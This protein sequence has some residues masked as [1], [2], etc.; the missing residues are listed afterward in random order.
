MTHESETSFDERVEE[1]L[2]EKYGEHH[3]EH[4]VYLSE[5]GRYA[6]FHVK[7]PVVELM[8]EVENDFEACFKGT[9]QALLYAAH[10]RNAVPVIIAPPGHVKEPEAEMLSRHV[11][12]IELDA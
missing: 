6:D 8:I 9:G 2:I 1:Y 12:I 3:V 11:P 4:N 10:S 7:G 5:S